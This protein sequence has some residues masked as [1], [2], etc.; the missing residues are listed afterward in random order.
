MNRQ[1]A[2]NFL[3]KTLDNNGL[4]DWKVRIFT[5]LNR[6]YLGLCSH[7]DKAILLNGHHVDT[8]PEPE[9]KD[10]ILHEVAH[11]LVGPSNGQP[12]GPTW[13]TKAKELG[14]NCLSGCGTIGL[15]LDAIEA[16]RSGV[17]LEVEFEEKTIQ[18]QV[19]VEEKIYE[20][21]YK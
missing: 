14:V 13:V 19:T 20:P 2:T 10:T 3:R 5:D 7:K 18:R 11:A 1:D 4:K 17:T 21:R 15:N 9:V 6:P 12:H 16:I 8:H